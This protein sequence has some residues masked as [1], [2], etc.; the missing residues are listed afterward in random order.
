MS[1]LT[2][3]IV[4]LKISIGGEI[5]ASLSLQLNLGIT[6][7]PG[8]STRG[9][10]PE[11]LEDLL[12]FEAALI[13]ISELSRLQKSL[14]LN[15]KPANKQKTRCWWPVQKLEVANVHLSIDKS[16]HI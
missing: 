2:R 10:L 16:F 9:Y 15:T 1:L 6:R 7:R 4:Q 14:A 5:V 12:L 3:V 13:Y 8:R 11:Y